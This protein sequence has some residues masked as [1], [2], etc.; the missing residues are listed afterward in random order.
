MSTSFYVYE[1][2][3]EPEKRGCKMREIKFRS[4]I[5]SDNHMFYDF[6]FVEHPR[7]T[8]T[9]RSILM[10]YTGLKDKNGV[11]IYEGDILKLNLTSWCGI[12]EDVFSVKTESFHADICYLKAIAEDSDSDSMKIIGNVFENPELL[13]V[14]N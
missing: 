12:E 7:T 6:G 14:T 5:K 3:Y 4:W 9:D 11:E 2:Q 13:E 8:E 1:T 10:Q